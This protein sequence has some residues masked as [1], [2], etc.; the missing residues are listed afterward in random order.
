MKSKFEQ[1]M[2]FATDICKVV[3]ACIKKKFKSKYDLQFRNKSGFARNHF[4]E[5]HRK[6]YSR[7]DCVFKNDV[8]CT[9][10][11]LSYD[12]SRVGFISYQKYTTNFYY[13][14]YSSDGGKWVEV[15]F[16][17]FNDTTIEENHFMASL[18]VSEQLLTILTVYWHIRKNIKNNFYLD[19]DFLKEMVKY[20]DEQK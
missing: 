19:L 15:K 3:K 2:K 1:D 20:L 10:F 4:Y 8:E 18:T 12:D 13:F 16:D 5:Y 7:M 11:D 9:D 14:N 17:D 6:T